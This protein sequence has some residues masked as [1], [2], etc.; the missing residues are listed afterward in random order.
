MRALGIDFGTVHIGIA[1]TDS[2]RKIVNGLTTITLPKN[3]HHYAA[4]QI[5]K[6]VDRYDDIDLIVLGYPELGNHHHSSMT[7]QVEKFYQVLQTYVPIKIVLFDE[8]YS[9]SQTEEMLRNTVRLSA[10][11][12]KKIKDKMAAQ[13]ILQSY[14]DYQSV[15][16]ISQDDI[17]NKSLNDHIAIVRDQTLSALTNLIKKNKTRK[18]LEIGTAYGYS[19][20]AMSQMP[21]VEQLVTVEKNY[22]D[23]V[24]AR[25]NLQKCHNVCCVNASAFDYQ[26]NQKFD[27]IFLDGPKSHQDVLFNKFSENLNPN[28]V[29]FI[30]NIYLK[31]FNNRPVITKNQQK[32]INN[33]KAFRDWLKNLSD[34]EVNIFD[35]DDGYAICRKKIGPKLMVYV[36]ETKNI[37]HTINNT[38]CDIVV[39]GI[40]PFSDKINAFI[41]L[42]QLPKLLT[43][44]H[45]SKKMLY[46]ILD[47]FVFE[48]DLPRLQQTLESLHKIKIDGVIFND[49]AINQINYE[50]KL[51]LNLVYDPK[52]LIT[53]YG[54]FGFYVQNQINSVVL[55]NEINLRE[56]EECCDH[57]SHLCLIKQVAGYVFM[58]KS[59]W[60]LLTN[61]LHFRHL[62]QDL[63]NQK[64]Y[65][66][67]KQRSYP[68]II[69]QNEHG[70]HIYTGY[71]LTNLQYL[72]IMKNVDVFLIDGFLHS[73]EWLKQTIELY[74][75][76]ISKIDCDQK[77]LNGLLQKEKIINDKEATLSGFMK[78]SPD[79]NMPYLITDENN[80]HE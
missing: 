52:A 62:K 73:N 36:N 24:I 58:M 3:N 55:S 4:Q 77:T 38:L 47:A 60:Q 65:L 80:I 45:E 70:T 67:E 23:F 71:C 22:D 30:D 79:E 1:I 12:I 21:S 34:W 32:L 43:L 51:N 18:I 33:V 48:K 16:T 56:I 9:T 19:A 29:I 72:S 13:L 41:T 59:R 40:K 76:A 46:V 39:V 8:S 35:I 26:T 68:A 75:E 28:G 50:L 64:V 25:S 53:N 15:M 49:W 10:S 57:K 27:L 2:E 31:K 69:Y 44:A 14:L 78:L 7:N 42:K 54:Q 74:H 20:Y 11:K 6:I 63:S 66:M 61:F 37:V 5:K 17:K